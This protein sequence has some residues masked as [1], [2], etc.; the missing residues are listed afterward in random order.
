MYIFLYKFICILYFKIVIE[1]GIQFFAFVVFPGDG[2]L[3][4]DKNTIRT[5]RRRFILEGYSFVDSRKIESGL[6][7]V[8]YTNNIHTHINIKKPIS[9]YI[10]L[11]YLYF[12]S[13]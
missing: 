8:E 7:V 5:N 12:Q 1:Y 3:S 11:V 2:L 10:I 4:K 13:Q 6:I 9:I